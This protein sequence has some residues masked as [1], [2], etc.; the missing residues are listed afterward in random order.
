MIDSMESAAFVAL[1]NISAH[2]S[3]PLIGQD[4]QRR[5]R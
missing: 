1:C 4:I 3:R 5:N 2:R